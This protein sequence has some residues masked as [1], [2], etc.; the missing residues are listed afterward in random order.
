MMGLIMIVMEE[1]MLMN[2][3][4]KQLQN[5]IRGTQLIAQQDYMEFVVQVQERA[6]RMN[7][8]ENV[9]KIKQALLKM[10]RREIHVAILSTMIVMGW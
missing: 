3:N 1:K 4:V 2:Q 9:F 7:Y 6:V 8:G 5:V 10:M